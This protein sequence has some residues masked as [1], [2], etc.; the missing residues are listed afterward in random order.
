MFYKIRLLATHIPNNDDKSIKPPTNEYF[1]IKLET[2][3]LK[4]YFPPY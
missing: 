4:Q 3:I 1:C 2:L